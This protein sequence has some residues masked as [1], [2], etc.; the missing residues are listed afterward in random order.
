MSKKNK[1]VNPETEVPEND[2]NVQLEPTQ[3]DQPEAKVKKPSKFKE[4]F[5]KHKAVFISTA[6][7][8][9]R[10]V[11]MS[12]LV[13]HAETIKLDE[14]PDDDG[15][16]VSPDDSEVDDPIYSEENPE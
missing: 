3:D 8:F 1:K 2:P 16:E 7:G 4:A 12:E 14:L 13:H 6:A 10:G 5:K 9:L 11:T 15:F